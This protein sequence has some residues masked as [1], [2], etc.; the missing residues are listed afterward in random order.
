VENKKSYLM[1]EGF[2]STD[3]RLWDA[4]PGFRSLPIIGGFSDVV[5]RVLPSADFP[6]T[7]CFAVR[8]CH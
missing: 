6:T 2:R 1:S 7:D 8:W 5:R 4:A 3:F